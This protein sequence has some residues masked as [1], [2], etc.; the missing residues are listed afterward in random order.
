M[1][2]IATGQNGQTAS[3]QK[4]PGNSFLSDRGPPRLSPFAN[5]IVTITISQTAGRHEWPPGVLTEVTVTVTF[6][7][8]VWLPAG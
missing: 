6:V 7:Q 4:Q 8:Q 5:A 1:F 2:P 3:P